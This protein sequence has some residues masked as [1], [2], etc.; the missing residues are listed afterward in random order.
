MTVKEDTLTFTLFIKKINHGSNFFNGMF[1]KKLS[2]PDSR[3]GMNLYAFSAEYGKMFTPLLLN[4]RDFQ[5][6]TG[7]CHPTSNASFTWA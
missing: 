3:S 7:G 6:A 5:V 2:E 1:R 4:C